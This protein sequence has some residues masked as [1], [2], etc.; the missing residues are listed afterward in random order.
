MKNAVKLVLCLLVAV[1]TISSACASGVECAAQLVELSTMEHY[2]SYACDPETGKWSVHA[3]QADALMERFWDYGMRSSSRSVVFHLAAE[4]DLYTGV[5]SPVLRFYHID[6]GKINARAVSI[7]VNGQRYDL[8]ASSASVTHNRHTAECITVPLNAQGLQVAAALQQA[9]QATVRLIGDELYTLTFNRS[10]NTDR[11]AMEGA[12]LTAL[13]S[14]MA[15]FEEL[16][17]NSYA[18]W[19]LSAEAWENQYG[20]RPAVTEGTVSDTLLDEKMTDTM[21]MILP[22]ASGDVAVA[23]Q[24][25][26]IEH[27]FLSGTAYWKFNNQAVEAALR[28]QKYLGRVPTGCFDAALLDALMQGRSKETSTAP[29]MQGLGETAEIALERFWF[30]DGVSAS[31]NPES[32]R[33]VANA[34]NVFLA[35]DGQIR[36]LSV[37]E[38]HLFMQLD[39][40]VIYNGQYAYDAELVCEC[41]DGTVLDTRLLPLAQARLM[42]FAEIP[43]A[44]ADAAD[45]QWSIAFT[46]GSDTLVFD[47]Q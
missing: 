19:D 40:S 17:V 21:G 7:L 42:V 33:S 16:G 5:W 11:Q 29:L 23:A 46:C 20:Y 34:D 31:A 8:A 37:Q 47:L 10:A 15:L 27:G 6:G 12:S 38:L 45:A 36:N 18:L 25:A 39:A 13:A 44:L 9:E 14:G 28:A 2:P 43:T 24:E 41:S 4:G 30:A 22:D 3:Y 1:M 35:A 26:L 32:L